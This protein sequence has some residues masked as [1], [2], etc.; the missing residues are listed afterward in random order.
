MPAPNVLQI[1]PGLPGYALSIPWAEVVGDRSTY[2]ASWGNDVSQVS[3]NIQVNWEDREQA[4]REIL[5]YAVR[6][7]QGG[8]YKSPTKLQRVVPWRHPQYTWLRAA[9]I[10]PMTGLKPIGKVWAENAEQPSAE[11]K[12]E[13]I[14][15]NFSTLPFTCLTDDEMAANASLKEWDRFTFKRGQNTVTLGQYGSANSAIF[16]PTASPAELVGT[17][18]QGTQRNVPIAYESIEFTWYY[19]PDNYLFNASHRAPH[20]DSGLSKVNSVDWNGYNSGTLLF[21]G[22]RY[23]PVMAPVDPAFMNFA[24]GEPPRLWNVVF[25]FKY[26]EPDKDPTAGETG[27]YTQRGHNLAPNV[28]TNK[29]FD[30]SIATQTYWYPVL[31]GNGTAPFNGYD[32]ANFFAAV[33]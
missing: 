9:R 2:S 31:L 26:M 21:E 3:L 27:L 19:V 6:G 16:D 32:F 22:W 17:F 30:G 24:P 5:G 18:I 15:V 1:Q 4:V 25:S 12:F 14:T 8:T 20:I 28:K 29:R 13:Y 33:A 7:N 11:Y 10:G 23:E